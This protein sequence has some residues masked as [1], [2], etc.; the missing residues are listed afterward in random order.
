MDISVVQVSHEG[1][2]DYKQNPRN[3]P[4]DKYKGESLPDCQSSYQEN[5]AVDP[6]RAGERLRFLCSDE[7]VRSGIVMVTTFNS[8]S[9]HQVDGKP[10]EKDLETKETSAPRQIII[11]GFVHG[12]I[13]FI[14]D[15]MACISM[16]K[17]MSVS[18]RI[19]GN[20][21]RCVCEMSYDTIQLRR[22]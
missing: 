6:D 8:I 21:K 2:P 19:E 22:A 13:N 18:P 11:V 4:I 1:N 16:M 15:L 3:A 9:V 10:N 5:E 17:S 7:H 12:A 20:Q 14:F